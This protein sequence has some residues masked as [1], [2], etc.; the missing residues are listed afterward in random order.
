[1]DWSDSIAWIV[2]GLMGNA[3]F[4]S[5]FLVQWVASER[6][7]ESVI[8]RAFWHLSIVGSLLLLAY[9]IHKRDPIFILAYLPNAFVYIRNLVLIRRKETGGAEASVLQRNAPADPG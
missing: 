9:A 7:R 1:V 8:P 4:F 3:A 6:A 2:L 5:R